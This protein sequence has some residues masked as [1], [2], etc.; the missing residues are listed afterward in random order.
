MKTPQLRSLQVTYLSENSAHYELTFMN[1]VKVAMRVSPIDREELRK[2][3][4][5]VV[6]E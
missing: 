6:P 5:L 1:G 3:Q 2:L 4:L